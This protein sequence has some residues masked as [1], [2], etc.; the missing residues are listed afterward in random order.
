VE[1]VLGGDQFEDRIAEVLEAFVVGRTAL[2]V[3][4]VVGTMG[5]RLPEQGNVVEADAERP[6]KL[7]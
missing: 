6:L 5:Q 1:E 2:R 3:L 7:L 4:I